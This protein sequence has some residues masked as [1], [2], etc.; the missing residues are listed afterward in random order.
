MKI[1]FKVDVLFT[2]TKKIVFITTMNCR[3]DWVL[4]PWSLQC[5]SEDGTNITELES[6][7]ALKFDSTP[8]CW[9]IRLELEMLAHTKLWLS[10]SVWNSTGLLPSTTAAGCWFIAPTLA[11]HDTSNQWYMMKKNNWSVCV[12]VCVEWIF[13]LS[14]SFEREK[15]Q[16]SV[17]GI[18]NFQFNSV[19]TFGSILHLMQNR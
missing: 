3:K 10:R 18:Q 1:S 17:R 19:E 8:V 4:Q 13:E 6:R 16:F 5:V 12:C 14:P 11:K 9:C 2:Y 15:T 7:G